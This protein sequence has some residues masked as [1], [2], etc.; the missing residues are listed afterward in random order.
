MFS[1]ATVAS[2]TRMP[3]ASARPPSV[4]MLIVWPAP[5]SATTRR[6]QRERD[7]D[8]DNRRAAPVAQEQQ[9]HQARQ[10]RA[11]GRLVEH[12]SQRGRHV[13]RLVQLVGDR[14]VVGDER[15]EAAEVRLAPR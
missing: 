15:L 13:R 11:E 7:R 12:R 1:I 2:S 9:H 3:T 6:Q 14:D 4:M 10:E 8:H 5:H